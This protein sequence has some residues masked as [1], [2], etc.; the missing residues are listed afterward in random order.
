MAFQSRA[1]WLRLAVL[2]VGL[3]ALAPASARL[4]A[5]TQTRQVSVESLIYDLKSPD[6]LRRQA[7]ARDL[8]AAKHRAATPDLVAMAHDAVPAVRREVE[9]ALERMDDVQAMPGFVEFASDMENDIRARAVSSLVSMHISHASGV[10][11]VLTKLGELI[12]FTPDRDLEIVVEPDIPVDPVVVET[13]RA[14]LVDS[15]RGI[16]RTAIRGLGILRAKAAVP[17]LLQV[18][19][20]DRDDGLRFDGVRSLR[21]IDDR[22]IAPELVALLNI[23]SDGVRHELMATLGAMRYRG[24]VA[25]LT[26][27]VEGATKTDTPRVLALSA[28][29]DIADP[30]SASL[31]EGLKNDK[32]E[33]VRLYANEG[34]ARTADKSQ[35]S[36]ISAAR[37]TEKSPRVRTAQ[38]FA[39]LRIGESEYLDEL[40]RGLERSTTRELAKEYLLETKP[41]DREALFAPRTTSSTARAELADVMGR[42]GD[43]NALPRLQEL[44]H[45]SDGDVAR[46]AERAT[47]RIAVVTSSQE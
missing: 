13:L 31:F 24:A 16:R 25:E 22:S 47:R 9:L 28:L 1:R 46:A 36:A 45:D 7:A 3:L 12:T 20:Q 2:T 15:E 34:I 23:N 14:R 32:S 6:P 41:G 43:P 26:R 8:G 37:L 35:K 21:K 4:V 29:A 5:Q 42:I 30:A 44:A 40:V 18:V 33:L 38:A 10:G 19:R 27:I 11:A 17:D 39:L